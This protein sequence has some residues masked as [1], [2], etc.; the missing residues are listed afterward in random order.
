MQQETFIVGEKEF[1]CVRMNPF[2]ANKL[3]IRV[4]KIVMPVLGTLASGSARQS[5]MDVDVKVAAMAIAENVDESLMEN[6]VLPMF[7][8]AKLYSVTDK[9]FIKDATSIDMVFTTESLFDL[10]EI[11]WLVGRFQFAPFF[12]KLMERFGTTLADANT[13]PSLESSAKT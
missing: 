5:I 9:K 11:I 7:L 8:E 12:A 2:A 3:L 4:Q 13:P 6:I 1:T 10:Y